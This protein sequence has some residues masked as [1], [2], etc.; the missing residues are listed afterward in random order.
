MAITYFNSATPSPPDND[1]TGVAEPVTTALTPPSTMLAGDLVFFIGQMQ[2]AVTGQ[3]T[4]SEAGGQTWN[5]PYEQAANDQV[6]SVFWCTFNGTW[7]A[8]PSLAFAAQSGTQA[9]TTTMHVFRPTN[10]T[11]VWGVDVAFTGAN[12]NAPTT[13]FTVTITGQTTVN[14]GTVTLAIWCSSD[15]DT[16]SAASGAGWATPGDAQ[17]RNL[18]GTDQSVS[19]AYFIGTSA[20]QAT[21]DVSK[22]QGGV[23]GD[24][25]VT[26][27]VT[28]YAYIPQ[29]GGLWI[30]FVVSGSNSVVGGGGFTS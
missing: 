28:L 8:N 21:G 17:V 13:P 5:G 30:P 6:L 18:A 16:Y 22:N 7:S 27:I 19:A 15:D 10:T 29:P 12:F 25:G 24:A 2:A 1:A 3:I 14:A 26:G 9:A 23:A 11:Y 20:G 4:V